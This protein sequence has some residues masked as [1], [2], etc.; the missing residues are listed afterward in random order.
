M[1]DSTLR[2]NLIRLAHAKPE[3]R[4]HLLPLLAAGASSSVSSK[5]AAPGAGSFEEAVKGKKFRNP[6]TGKDVLF[7]SLPKEEQ[8]RVRAKWES[9]NDKAKP[10][11][12][13]AGKPKEAPEKKAPAKAKPSARR[14]PASVEPIMDKYSLKEEDAE[15]MRKFR[16]EKPDT[17]VPVPPSVLKQRFLAKASPET[18]ERMK[19]MAIGDFMKMLKAILS[20]EEG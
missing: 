17:K 14:V 13:Q 6:A 16:S 5:T 9:K 2:S 12:E 20:E 15:E 7:K 19:D 11:T 3:L 8:K 4:P 1:S 18:K 10:P